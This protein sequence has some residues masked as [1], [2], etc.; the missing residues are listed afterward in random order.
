MEF[1]SKIPDKAYTI[2]AYFFGIG[3]SLVCAAAGVIIIRSS[4]FTYVD[5]DTQIN[6]SSD[7]VKQISN[8]TE[9]ANN[10]LLEK[11]ESLEI[12][13]NQLQG[14]EVKPLKEKVEELRPVAKEIAKSNQELKEELSEVE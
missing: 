10:Q 9:Y 7:R 8:N 12:E 1:L 3:F 5:K 6:L 13:I 4:N 11:I 2:L 14:E